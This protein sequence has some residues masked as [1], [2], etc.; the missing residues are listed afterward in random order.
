MNKNWQNDP[1]V[2]CNSPSNL[3]ELIEKN[4]NF[5]KE[6]EKIEPLSF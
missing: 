2:C 5:E 1:K 6:L 4:L 3:L